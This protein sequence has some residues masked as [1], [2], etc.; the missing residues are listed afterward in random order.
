MMK[1]NQ[2]QHN[3]STV[4]HILTNKTGMRIIHNQ[5]WNPLL[6]CRIVAAADL[7]I[8]VLIY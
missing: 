3:S 6:A 1:D 8:F 7:F 4:L 5:M 2:Y